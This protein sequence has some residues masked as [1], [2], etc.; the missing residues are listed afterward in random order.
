MLKE[1]ST[2]KKIRELRSFFAQFSAGVV[3]GYSAGVD[4]AFLAKVAQEVLGQKAL[5]VTVVSEFFTRRE[6]REAVRLAKENDLYHRLLSI[7]I[8]DHPEVAENSPRRCYY[9]KYR[10]FSLLQELAEKEGYEA[11]MDGANSDDAK[12]YRPG[13]EA[14]KELGARSPLEEIGFTK[15]EIRAAAKTLGLS[16]WQKPASACLASRFPYGVPLRQE[17]LLRVEEGEEYLR[18]LGV[19]QARLRD[20]HP[21]AR[22]EALPADFSLIIQQKA[23]VVAELKKIGYHYVCLDLEGYQTGSLNR[24]I[25]D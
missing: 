9:C 1:L 5:A 6:A 22:V 11:V 12:D 17:G 10:I 8:L 18:S 4:S 14:L 16:N 20:H 24:Q 21:V 2:E 7:K 15:S 23:E 25:R 13:R 3:I 19:G